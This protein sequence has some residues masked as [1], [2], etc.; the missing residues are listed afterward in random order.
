M[1]ACRRTLRWPG[2]CSP[3]CSPAP[4]CRRRSAPTISP[5]G[6]SPP[7]PAA[8]GKPLTLAIAFDP[9]RAGTATGR[10]PA[11]RASGWSST[12]R[13]PPGWSA[14]E[15]RYPV[16]QR[17]VIGGLMNH[18]YEAHYAV[19]VPVAV[20]RRPRCRTSR[21]SRSRREWLACTDKICVPEQAR[22]TLDLIGAA[23]PRRRASTSGAPRCRRCS[24]ARRASRSTAS[25]CAS[26]FR[27]P[28]RCAGRA[29]RV[30]RR[31]RPGATT[32]RRRRFSRDG[33]LLIAEVPLA[34]DCGD[35]PTRSSGILALG[36]AATA[37]A[38]P[39]APGV[40]PRG[41]MPV[42]KPQ[43]ATPAPLWLLLLGALAGGLLL[44]VMPCVFPILSLKALSLARAGE[45]DARRGARGWPIPPGVVLALPGA[46]R[47]AAG[48]ARRRARRSAGRSSCR[49]PAWSWRCW[50]WR[51]R[52]PPICWACSSCRSLSLT[53]G[54]EP[55]GRVRHRAARGVRRDAVHRAVHG[56]GD[57]RGAAA[58]GAPGAA[59]VRRAGARAGAAVPRC[60]A[61]SRRCAR[62]LPRPGPWMDA[63][64]PLDGAA[65]GADRAGAAVAGVAAGRRVVRRRG[66]ARRA[67][68]W[69]ALLA[70]AGRRQRAGA[71]AGATFALVALP[72]RCSRRSRFPLRWRSAR[73]RRRARRPRRPAVQRGERWPRRA[74][75]G[76]PVF[77]WFTADW[78]LTCKVNEQRRDR[79]RGDPRRVRRGRRGRAAR[80]LDPA[81]SGDHPLSDRARRGRSAA[82]R[83]V[84]AGR[85][86][87]GPAAGARA[88]HAGY[89]GAG[90]CPGESLTSGADRRRHSSTSSP[91][92][93]LPSS[94]SVPAPGIVSSSLRVPVSASSR[95]SLGR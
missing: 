12:G 17:L 47:A 22:L 8:P 67:G 15:P 44:N 51:W 38:S 87:Q 52:S 37:C 95:V 94:R 49:S 92:R 39:R 42:D 13:C 68:R 84:R 32:P 4:A 77:V 72:S 88:R 64:P 83:V 53:R 40:V 76:K 14:G 11:T 58:A 24:T 46:R 5:R 23:A 86:R 80:R 60:S 36:E 20:P 35:G 34:R 3:C 26:R 6:W 91:G 70:L 1:S 41:G 55:A 19:L 43:A 31:A 61:S 25:T 10:T 93:A 16:P 56:R 90:N 48:P 33:D 73:R 63:L 81:R 54:G 59:A 7:G 69:S 75:A 45:S 30:R 85:G 65:D 27:C 57:G 29:A 74:P 82:L 9:S 62:M 28:P 66:C 71:K 18:V 21:R 2:C 79:A 89:S 78:C 50:C